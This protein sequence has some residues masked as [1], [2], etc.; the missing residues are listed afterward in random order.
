MFRSVQ[1]CNYGRSEGERNVRSYEIL[2]RLFDDNTLAN[3]LWS[4]GSS[5]A[6]NPYQ[7]TSLLVG[8]TLCLCFLHDGHGPTG[9]EGL[10]AMPLRAA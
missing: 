1:L 7:C 8:F 10:K 9:L 3:A 5:S 6:Y 4:E 2:L